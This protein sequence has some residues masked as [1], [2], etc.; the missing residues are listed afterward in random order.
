MRIETLIEEVY[1]TLKDRRQKKFDSR[2]EAIIDNTLE[3][4]E[5]GKGEVL[6]SELPDPDIK[7]DLS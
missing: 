6:I 4:L 2:E 3:F 7:N 1:L 5:K